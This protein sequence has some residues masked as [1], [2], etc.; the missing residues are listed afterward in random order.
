LLRR[1]TDSDHNALQVLHHILIGET[2]HAISARC[3]PFIAPAVMAKTGFEIVAL[4]V[5][6]NNELAGMR[7]EIRDVTAH[8]AL[9][10]KSESGKPV[11]FQ[12]A[13]QQGFGAR[14]RAS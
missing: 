12:V 14:H 4:A 8:R 6:F 1:Q 10:A 13:P 3:K 9:S 2:E 7:D 11:C 5:D